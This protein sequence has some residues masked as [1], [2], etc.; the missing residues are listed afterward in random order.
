MMYTV[1]FNLLPAIQGAPGVY[2]G[3]YWELVRHILDQH[4]YPGFT[5]EQYS[6]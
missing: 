1:P 3:E 4:E 6:R 5:A 2:F